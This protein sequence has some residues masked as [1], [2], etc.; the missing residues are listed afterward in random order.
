MNHDSLR[1]VTAYFFYVF[2]PGNC[3]QTNRIS[4]GRFAGR[5]I[6]TSNQPH[7][8]VCGSRRGLRVRFC[9]ILWRWWVRLHEIELIWKKYCINHFEPVGSLWCCEFSWCWSHVIFQFL[10]FCRTRYSQHEPVCSSQVS[11]INRKS[12]G[13][14]ITVAFGRE[15][16]I[17]RCCTKPAWLL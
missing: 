11:R 16:L 17:S 8:H 4:A 2:K 15:I 5:T 9:L 10:C 12:R 6:R 14:I 13:F 3:N 1:L 7:H